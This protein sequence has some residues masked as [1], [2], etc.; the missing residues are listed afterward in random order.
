MVKKKI[1]K[2]LTLEEVTDLLNAP[3]KSNVRDRLILSLMA[4][5]GLRAG[6]LVPSLRQEKQSDGTIKK[7]MSSGL[8]K[9]DLE[10]DEIQQ[11][12]R[13]MVEGGKGSKDRL[14]PV[15]LDVAMLYKDYSENMEPEAP[16]FDMCRQSIHPLVKRYA[17]RAGIKRKVWPH[18]LRH[19]FAKRA[20]N[21]GWNIKELQEVL[22]H[23]SLTTTQKYLEITEEEMSVV[24]KRH[25]LPY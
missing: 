2:S 23:E 16:L 24:H 20:L 22:G 7:W 9:I 18:L 19:T 14:I 5:C 12:A 17:E 15:P 11:I 13:L 6:E 1:P 25:P 21:A 10:F 4:K 8:K 3:Y